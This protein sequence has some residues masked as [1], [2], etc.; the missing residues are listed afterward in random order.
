MLIKDEQPGGGDRADTDPPALQRPR[1]A[2]RGS[3]SG[4]G[5]FGRGL[6]LRSLSGA[7]GGGGD[8]AGS[9]SGKVAPAWEE[10]DPPPLARARAEN[11][12]F[13]FTHPGPRPISQVPSPF[14]QVRPS[15]RAGRALRGSLSG[16]GTAG[17]SR[18]ASAGAPR[19]ATRAITVTSHLPHRLA[20]RTPRDAAPQPF[21]PETVTWEPRPLHQGSP[22]PAAPP[23]PLGKVGAQLVSF[24]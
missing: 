18:P 5:L 2:R 22:G 1:A 15:P 20:E 4:P 14:L 16:A 6:A 12:S 8:Q 10:V 19:P 24:K 23:K 13:L 17:P 21:T 7:R 11:S 3:V 9:R